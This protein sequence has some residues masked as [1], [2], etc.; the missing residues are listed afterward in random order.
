MIKYIELNE[1]RK[2]GKEVLKKYSYVYN[3]K[4][5]F[6]FVYFL[7][8][9]KGCKIG[10][11][12][13]LFKR[14]KALKNSLIDAQV[15]Y[16]LISPLCENWKDIEKDFKEKFSSYNINNEWFSKE[17]T[18]EYINFLDCQNYIFS[19]PSED[20]EKLLHNQSEATSKNIIDYFG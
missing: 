2:Y 11:T 19:E 10:I 14:L 20:E 13:D 3:F 12:S 15:D 17:H 7:A 1:A 18:E 8:T 6:G 16:V 5:R 9:N 4:Y